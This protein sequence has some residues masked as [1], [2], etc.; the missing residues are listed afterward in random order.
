MGS[1]LEYTVMQIMKVL[2]LR[3]LKGYDN[4]VRLII[5]N[6]KAINVWAGIVKEINNW[7][8]SILRKLSQYSQAYC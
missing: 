1:S 6:Q 2:G 5:T 3:N 4:H 7:V 8:S